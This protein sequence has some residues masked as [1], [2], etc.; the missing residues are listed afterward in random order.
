MLKTL[1]RLKY[2][3]LPG[4]TRALAEEIADHRERQAA[5]GL[6][7][8]AFGNDLLLRERS[9]DAWGWMW[10]D[11]TVRD[12]RHAARRLRRAPGFTLVAVASLALGIGVNL[13]VFSLVDAVA[14]QPLNLPHP[15]RLISLAWTSRSW[16]YPNGWGTSYDD[17]SGR[18]IDTSFS[19]PQLVAWSR[20]P[21][22]AVALL[23][24]M[25]PLNRVDLSVNGTATLGSALLVSESFQALLDV[26]PQLGRGLDAGDFAPGAPAAAVVTDEYWR[27]HLAGDPAIVGKTLA[28]NRYPVTIV[29]V[30][31]SRFQRLDLEHIPD[32]LLPLPLV[33]SPLL[34]GILRNPPR[35]SDGKFGFLEVVGRLAPGAT[36]EQ[37]RTELALSFSQQTKALPADP[38]NHGDWPT[39]LVLS[40]RNAI[41]NEGA[42]LTL[43]ALLAGGLTLLV[44]LIVAVNLANLL[45]ARSAALRAE[46]A[47][48][49]AL[50]AGRMALIRQQ[51]I[52]CALL[53]ALGALASLPIGIASARAISDTFV[54]AAIHAD[55]RLDGS[56]LAVAAGLAVFAAALSGFVPAW[57]ATRWGAE[58]GLRPASS[59]PGGHGRVARALIV[60]QIALC[61]TVLSGGSLFLRSIRNLKTT[62][63]GIEPRGL[64][65]LNLN[66]AHEGYSGARLGALFDLV[67][68]RLRATP[69]VDSA[70]E[71]QIV[72]GGDDMETTRSISLGAQPLP[73]GAHGARTDL[74]VVGTQFFS[75]YRIPLLAGR[76]FSALDGASATPVAIVSSAMARRFG[77]QPLGRRFFIGAQPW[78]VVG[79][80]G[81]TVYNGM[82]TN[83]DPVVFLPVAQSLAGA[84][85]SDI[86][87]VVRSSLPAPALAAIFRN[88]VHSAD[89]S[90]PVGQIQTQLA[91]M[92]ATYATEQLMATLSSVLAGLALALA[93]VGL[94][95][96]MAYAVTQ[97]AREIGVRMALGARRSSVL[98]LFLRQTAVLFAMGAAL[99]L[100]LAW[101]STRAFSSLLFG[102]APGDPAT[103][104]SA[105]GFLL[106]VALAAAWFP[107]RRASRLDP[108]STLRCD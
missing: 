58:A 74:A 71:A 59:A 34:A 78:T 105:A 106:L 82:R 30:A 77:G 57:R 31:S 6:P 76:D 107:A 98:T 13:G 21:R 47:I 43:P 92:E 101:F 61:L 84:G 2:L 45:L 23:A 9:R 19:N 95:G 51:M 3:L 90:I 75:T 100:P 33:E 11:N 108:L 70:T 32:V 102:V 73:P 20:Q 86:T 87:F 72:L 42:D 63:T 89:A 81:N 28:I 29:G 80:A 88:V 50:G 35:L 15:D 7:A 4:R 96:L 97:R 18:A 16:S 25:R 1:R 79:I 83:H 99:G 67:L 94:Y 10:L 48:R 8:R 62:P 53:A 69:G 12:L 60:A 54:P 41:N 40:A 22:R 91:A 24:G 39:L 55:P 26:P 36:L 68:G 64:T 27:A 44:L 65:L 85:L 104:A 49:M 93:A 56:V 46:L 37:A 17:L 5:E 38:D 103:L 14:L 66:P 52:E